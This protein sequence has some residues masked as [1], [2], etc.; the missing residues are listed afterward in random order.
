[1]LS[2]KVFPLHFE[3][4]RKVTFQWRSAEYFQRHIADP[5][6]ES[7]AKS[8]PKNYNNGLLYTSKV[9]TS[10]LTVLFLLLRV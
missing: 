8:K 6:K 3:L 9:G 1:M 4:A 5:T 2:S 10:R 7:T